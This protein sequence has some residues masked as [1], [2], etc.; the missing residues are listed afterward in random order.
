VTPPCPCCDLPEQQGFAATAEVGT[1]SV[2][3]WLDVEAANQGGKLI[4]A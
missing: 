2:R 4:D 1:A 3:G